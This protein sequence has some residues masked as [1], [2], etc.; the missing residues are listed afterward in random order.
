MQLLR[1][2]LVDNIFDKDNIRVSCIGGGPGSDII[3]VLKY[4]SDWEK[5]EPVSKITCYLLDSEQAWADT[6]TELDGCLE[7]DVVLNVNFQPLDVTKPE[8]WRSQKKFLQADL[9]TM[10]YF[11]SE[12]LSLDSDGVITTFWRTLFEEAKPGAIFLYDDNDH[13]DFNSY[14]DAQWKAAGLECLVSDERRFTP[15]S[16]EQSSEL[17]EYPK[18]FNHHP[19]LQARLC[20]R[21]LRKP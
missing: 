11:V 8:S 9:F 12:V 5:H 4:L 1:E 6:W 15:R 2:E 16:S 13:T 14:F 10:S 19:K 21:V 17:G 7:M 20:Y 3:A 18:K